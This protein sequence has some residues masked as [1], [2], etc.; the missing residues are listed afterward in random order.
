[1][2]DRFEAPA[3]PGEAPDGDRRRIETL[4]EL[5]ADVR[6][7]PTRVRWL[8]RSP[9]PFN[10]L[11]PTEI[12][13]VELEDGERVSLFQKRLGTDEARHPD[14]LRPDREM[15]VYEHLL[16]EGGVA[17]PRY[18]GTRVDDESGHFELYLEHIADW[19]LRYQGLE[20]WLEAARAL[21]LLHRAFS[22]RV[23]EEAFLL[24]LDRGYLI[25][26]AE[27]AAAAVEAAPGGLGRRVASLLA[28][29]APV[30][31]LLAAQPRTLVHNDLAPKNVLADRS[32]VPA[33]ICL[34]DWEVAGAGC[35]LLD[36]VH[37]GYGLEESQARRLLDSYLGA[38]E[39]A[40]VVPRS[41]SELQRVLAAARV[42]KAFYRLAHPHLWHDKPALAEEWA[43][44]AERARA[45]V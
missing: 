2:T 23:G 32:R 33:R 39:D 14:K 8:R 20:H 31:E 18:Y 6:G 15:L 17:A 4:Q 12:L 9:C 5:L 26:W 19:D 7:A 10:T 34:V 27:R 38:L 35:G 28:A 13:D 37:L 25:A 1:M 44:E 43:A 41:A 29:H 24:S 30:A 16:G 22:G 36:L 21:A 45:S 40:P 11:W 3:R 42:H